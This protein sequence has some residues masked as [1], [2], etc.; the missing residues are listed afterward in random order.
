MHKK[1][2]PGTIIKNREVIK[3]LF[4]LGDKH[5]YQVKCL[6]CGN[7]HTSL[8]SSLRKN[9][10]KGCEHCTDRGGRKWITTH[11]S[12]RKNGST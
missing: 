8:S 7:L 1:I 5:Y 3:Y 6:V 4:S 10:S 12:N 11:I 9:K 2:K